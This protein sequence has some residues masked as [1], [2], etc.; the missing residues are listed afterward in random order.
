MTDSGKYWSSRMNEF[1]DLDEEW[2]T[3]EDYC[4]QRDL[5][6]DH[7]QLIREGLA[8]TRRLRTNGLPAPQKVPHE[9]YGT[10]NGYRRCTLDHWYEQFRARQEEQGAPHRLSTITTRRLS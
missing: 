4:L 7:S 9:R 8:I 10:V 3:L 1:L 2:L 6:L 5:L